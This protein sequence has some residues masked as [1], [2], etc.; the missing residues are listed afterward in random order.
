M[1]LCD[2][3]SLRRLSITLGYRVSAPYLL[4]LKSTNWKKLLLR[5]DYNIGDSSPSAQTGREFHSEDRRVK[6]LPN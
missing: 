3:A 5:P 2:I 1:L 4:P 6:R